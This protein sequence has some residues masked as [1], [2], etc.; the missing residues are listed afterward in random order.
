[1]NWGLTTLGILVMGLTVGTAASSLRTAQPQ[2]SQRSSPRAE[3]GAQSAHAPYQR[4]GTWYE[5]ML[6]QFNPNDFDYGSWIERER[7][8]FI[9]AR[10]KNPYFLYSLSTSI[11]LLLMTTLYTKLWIDHRRA[12]WVTAEM[13]AD[14]YNQDAYSRQVAQEAI[15]KYNTHVEHCNRAIEAAEHGEASSG[16]SPEVE[17]LR[18]ELMRIAEER[19]TATRERDVARED[20]RKKAEIL[21]EM[22]VRLEAL[23]SKPGITSNAKQTPD[24]RGADPRLVSH[25]N[26]LQEQLYAERNNSRRLRG[27]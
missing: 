23:A 15:E 8:A 17:K 25:I 24:V 5:F 26:N 3:A 18:S 12:M 6:K 13:M 27:G 14:V 16:L 9:E 20:L 22:S 2:R 1:V 4:Q 21:A 19:D 11:G 10:I 7:Q